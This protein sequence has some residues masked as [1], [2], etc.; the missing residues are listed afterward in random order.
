MGIFKTKDAHFGQDYFFQEAAFAAET[1]TSEAF[2]LGCTEGGIRVHGWV[3]GSA[4]ASSGAQ[5]VTKL[6]VADSADAADWREIES[7]AV[8]AAGTAL[9][10]DLFSF[11]PDVD[12]KFM[13]VTVA[14]G[15]GVEG[16][17]SV[18]PEYVP[19]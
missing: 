11:I 6:E 1:L 12:D 3:E 15:S 2:E 19:R 5:V 18:A 14:A 7:Q 17:F 9:S 16:K 13:R 8:T 10:G 4:A